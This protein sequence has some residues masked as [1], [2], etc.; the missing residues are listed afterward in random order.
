MTELRPLNAMFSSNQLFDITC[1][2]SIL[3]HVIDF[4]FSM[5]GYK[6]YMSRTEKRMKPAWQITSTGLYCLGTGS[7]EGLPFKKNV[8]EDYP[9]YYDPSI[10][11]GIVAQHIKKQPYPESSDT[12]GTETLGCRVR[13]FPSVFYND[14]K[15]AE[16]IKSPLDCIICIE[17]Y[18]I[19]YDK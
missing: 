14:P 4:A 15:N 17:P 3:P 5:S 2:L 7:I 18:A 10:L 16:S 12:D 11:A 13:S 1:E 6:D 19:G 9:F 8:W